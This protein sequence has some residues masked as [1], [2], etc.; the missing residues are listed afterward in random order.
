MRQDCI[1]YIGQSYTLILGLDTIGLYFPLKEAFAR[2]YKLPE[3]DRR[4]SDGNGL[5]AA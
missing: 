4:S 2:W 1:A 5:H 3:I